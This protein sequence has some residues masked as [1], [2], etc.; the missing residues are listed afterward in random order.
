VFAV[1]VMGGGTVTAADL[2]YGRYL[3]AECVTCHQVSGAMEGIPAIV[4]WPE[5]DFVAAMEAYK[6]GYRDHD[7]MR[8]IAARYGTDEIAALAAYFAAI[9][10][11]AGG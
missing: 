7:L 11:E 4:G 8:T 5:P 3:A 1:L 2:E 10:D 6:A 9:G